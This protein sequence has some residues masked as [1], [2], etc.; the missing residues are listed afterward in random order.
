MTR[1]VALLALLLTAPAAGAE[2]WSAPA[3]VPMSADGFPALSFAAG[4][5]GLLTYVDAEG[6]KRARVRP[7]GAIGPVRRVGARM[8]VL[9]S[10]GYA[11][12]AVALLG[13]TF[14][15][16][17]GTF[18][19]TGSTT[20]SF[21]RP[22]RIVDW[23]SRPLAIAGNDRGD[24]AVM[25]AYCE[26][27]HRCSRP[28]AGLMVRR[29]GTRSFGR[30]ILLDPRG[31]AERAA[32]WLDERGDALAAWERP[33]DGISGTR[34]IYARVL[35][36]GGRLRAT[37]R[38]GT[39][40]PNPVLSA[41]L[42]ADRRAAV[43]WLSQDVGGGVARGPAT[44]SLAQAARRRPFA[45]ARVLERVDVRGTGRHVGQAG[46]RVRIARGR[47]LAAWTGYAGGR[48]VVRAARGDEEPQIV[49]DPARD[50]VLSDLVVG[51]GGEAVV[52][53]LE[54]IRGASPNA[55][56]RGDA[57]DV[58]VVAAAR[59]AR[60]AAFG[61]LERVADARGEFREAVDL[62][63]SPTTGRVVAVWRDFGVEGIASAVRAPVG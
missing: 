9:R 55:I 41:V 39:S 11:V 50:T 4:G 19:A 28:V 52:A 2:P 29:A 38:L 44:I 32:L 48:F 10:T 57:G 51:P 1:R 31:P 59:A 13:D 54:G 16:L 3:K 42:G 26:Q 27:R 7:D 23:P 60:A 56:G 8:R 33:L 17:P 24:L 58:A 53:G 61:P 25:L 43:A 49:S 14:T 18:L 6:P 15:G 21:D 36:R 46:V 40:V 12:D 30:P 47:T 37:Q 63:I 34:G 62:G 20:S 45:P 35:T 22:R 5:A